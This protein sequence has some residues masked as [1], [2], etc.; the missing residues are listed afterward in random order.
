MFKFRSILT[1]ALLV[2]SSSQ[3]F[4]QYKVD[5]REHSVRD[6]FGS[7]IGRYNYDFIE[8]NS[9]YVL[10]H[11]DDNHT[12]TYW[13]RDGKYYY[14]PQ[15]QTRYRTQSQVEE[16]RFGGRRHMDDLAERL[17]ALVNETCLELHYNYG[18]NRDFKQTY[19]DAYRILDDAKWV[20]NRGNYGNSSEM[21]RRLMRMDEQIHKVQDSVRGWNSSNRRSYGDVSLRSRLRL[22]EAS[23]H[24]LMYDAGIDPDRAHDDNN[25]NNGP[26]RGNDGRW[27]DGRGNDGR[28]GYNGPGYN[29][30]G[31]G[32]NNGP[33]RGPG[34]N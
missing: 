5:R 14:R 34:R 18:H 4:A 31:P 24:H 19:A 23:I 33:G 7:V 8:D 16:M 21:R 30:N 9:K 29:N 27:N 17:E 32:Y 2:A 25:N 13:N 28:P 12:G 3:A 6:E 22:V 26:G 11:Y 10:P 1:V 15:T 20:H